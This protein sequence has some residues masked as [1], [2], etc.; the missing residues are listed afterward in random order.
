MPV[1]RYQ[2]PD[3]RIARFEVPDG[4]TPEQAQQIGA[5][6]FAQQAPEPVVAQVH[7]QPQG[8]PGALPDNVENARLAQASVY[9]GDPGPSLARKNRDALQS[10]RENAPV[11]QSFARD[12][13]EIGS[14]PELN[15][16]SLDAVKSS[17]AANLINSD[18]E[19]AAALEKNIPGAVAAQDPEGNPVIRM[20]SGGEYAIN[21]PGL[22]GQDFAK[23]ASRML[24]FIPSGRGVAGASKAALG[25]SAGQAVATETGLQG[26]ESAVGGEFSPEEVAAAGI[27]A[28]IGQVV[29]DKIIGP[30]AQKIAKTV[31]EAGS[32]KLLSEAAPSIDTLKSSARA[33]YDQIDESGAV[34]RP[35]LFEGFVKNVSST[36]QKEGLDP[37]LTPQAQGLLKRLVTEVDSGDITV[38][39]LDT[40]R[41]VAKGVADSTDP[42]D[43]RLGVIA[44]NKIDDLIERLGPEAFEKSANVRIN[45]KPLSEAFKD[46]RNLWGRARRAE[47]LNTAVELASDQASG[48]ENGLR[49]QFR[50]VLNKINK[51]QLKGFSNEEKEAIRKVVQGGTLEN[52]VKQLGKLGIPEDQATNSLMLT[53]VGGAGFGAGF[54]AGGPAGGAAGTAAAIGIPTVFRRIATNLTKNNSDLAQA[55]VKSK[56]NGLKLTNAYMANVPKS[57]RDPRE[58]AGIL[59]NGDANL[60]A[61]KY[62]GNKLIDDAV[63][64]AKAALKAGATTEDTEVDNQT[65]Q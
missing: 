53:L 40:L 42:S 37:D 8:N 19:L 10:F 64:L 44:V 36:L 12:L 31:K 20:P 30:A 41:K 27:A 43:A 11:G 47:T 58:L 49:I 29:G 45:G 57:A 34:I 46:A 16:F 48:F 5:D 63:F 33:I 39:R 3:G 2:L 56:G 23:F 62:T 15:E 13:P 25:R 17:L 60:E 14:A 22:S 1:A 52:T 51:G 65:I 26:V 55:I 21:K 24:A 61:Y 59:L 54:A 18:A 9:G 6:Y 28:P 32:K 35:S 38:S 50:S 7:Q 4:T